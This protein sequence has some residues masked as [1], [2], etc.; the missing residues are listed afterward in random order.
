MFQIFDAPL[1]K[2]KVSKQMISIEIKINLLK[3]KVFYK[4]TNLLVWVK[5]PYFH[6]KE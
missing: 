5:K 2:I 3:E 6:S 1:N 4:V